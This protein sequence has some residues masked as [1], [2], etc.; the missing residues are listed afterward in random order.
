MQ[1][2]YLEIQILCIALIVMTVL[3]GYACRVAY[4]RRTAIELPDVPVGTLYFSPDSDQLCV[5]SGTE[6]AKL[7]EMPEGYHYH[8]VTL[9]VLVPGKGYHPVAVLRGCAEPDDLIRIAKEQLGEGAFPAS[10]Y[11][12]NDD[13]VLEPTYKYDVHPLSAG[14]GILI[15]KA[16]KVEMIEGI[17][18]ITFSTEDIGDKATFK[19][20]ES[21]ESSRV[22]MNPGE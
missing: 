19:L 4:K 14:F 2:T 17:K 8:T 11:M 3:I 13:G 5:F 9:K 15:E 10:Y 22:Q 21:Y 7:E 20:R 1:F 6:W 18:Y 12:P 16:P